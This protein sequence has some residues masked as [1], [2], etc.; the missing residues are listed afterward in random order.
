MDI[1]GVCYCN[2]LFYWYVFEGWDNG[3]CYIYVCWVIFDVFI[4][5]EELD[6]DVVFVDV[7]IFVV[8]D[9]CWDVLDSF[10]CYFIEFFGDYDFVFFFVGCGGND[11]FYW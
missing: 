2:V 9:Y 4:S 3:C 8:F 6:V 11:G 5:L 10:F 1:E 7:F